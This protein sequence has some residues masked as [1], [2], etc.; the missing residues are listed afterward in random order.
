[1]VDRFTPHADDVRNEREATGTSAFEAQ[2]ALRRANLLREVA[3]IRDERFEST[4]S[5]L[6]RLAEVVEAMLQDCK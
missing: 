6:D 2:R 5:K 1:M 4:Q 3:N